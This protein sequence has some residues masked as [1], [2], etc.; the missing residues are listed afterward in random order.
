[1]GPDSVQCRVCGTRIKITT[2][3]S[4]DEPVRLIHSGAVALCPLCQGSPSLGM[5]VEKGGPLRFPSAAA[6]SKPRHR[7]RA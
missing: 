3:S 5:G 4:N 6:V 1:M 2:F 7:A